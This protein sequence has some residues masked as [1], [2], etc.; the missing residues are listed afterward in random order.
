MQVSLLLKASI[1]FFLWNLVEGGFLP[2]YP[3]RKSFEFPIQSTNTP[4]LLTEELKNFNELTQKLLYGTWSS[5]A[6]NS[7]DGVTYLMIL[8]I[9]FV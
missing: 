3:Y 2:N 5:T 9:L 4:L 8:V 6:E 7:S 1:I